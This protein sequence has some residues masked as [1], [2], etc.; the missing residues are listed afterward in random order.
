MPPI[1]LQAAILLVPLLVITIAFALRDVRRL[2]QSQKSVM[3]KIKARAVSGAWV[4]G[5][6]IVS[7]TSVQILSD[8][9]K[10]RAGVH[11]IFEEAPLSVLGFVVA[12]AAYT[13]TILTK[14]RESITASKAQLGAF[15]AH[16]GLTEVN[17]NRRLVTREDVE[18]SLQ[19]H[20]RNYE[21]L[22]WADF[23]L[24]VTGLLFVGTGFGGT[25]GEP[26]AMSQSLCI[27]LLFTI[28]GYFAVLHVRQ[29]YK[30][31]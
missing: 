14:L 21:W 13:S 20:R 11:D 16:S 23:L 10:W 2:L 8:N 18:E 1:M 28:I 9:S 24:V 7:F 17:G 12:L 22:V 3:D 27:A 30:R 15:E 25:L 5:I 4:N 19:R 29:W 26:S 31:T 6:L